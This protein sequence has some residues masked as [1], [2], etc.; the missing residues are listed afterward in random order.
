MDVWVK[1]AFIEE[2]ICNDVIGPYGLVNEDTLVKPLIDFLVEYKKKIRM[3][4]EKMIHGTKCIHS[5]DLTWF[6][7]W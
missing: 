7:L 3:G 6:K 4:N 5:S 2:R 1:G